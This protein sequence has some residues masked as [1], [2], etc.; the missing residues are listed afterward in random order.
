MMVPVD[1]TPSGCGHTGAR[2]Y[3]LVVLKGILMQVLTS[4]VSQT[5]SSATEAQLKAAFKKRDY[6]F[7]GTVLHTGKVCGRADLQLL[8]KGPFLF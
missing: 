5:S 6:N 8:A 4:V 1:A 7:S 3:I 2:Q